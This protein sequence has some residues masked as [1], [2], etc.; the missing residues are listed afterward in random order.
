MH[1]LKLKGSFL[2][3]A[4]STFAL[5]LFAASFDPVKAEAPITI[6]ESVPAAV[7]PTAS[8]TFTIAEIASSSDTLNTLAVAIEAAEL[9]DVLNSAGP[10]TIFA[11]TDDAFAALPPEAID[12]L[13]L[14]E[15]RE[16]LVK[17]LTYH[18]VPGAFLSDD[19]E[20]GNIGTVEGSTVAIGADDVISVNSAQVVANDVLASNGVIHIIDRV[21]IPPPDAAVETE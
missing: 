20:T 8:E 1:Y 13:L 14:P 17:L 11:P 18:V 9:M 4:A 5:S 7:D 2:G 6:P 16:A 15:N 21:I 19:L 3:L 12:A 10:F